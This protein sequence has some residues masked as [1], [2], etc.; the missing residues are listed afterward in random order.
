MNDH[1]HLQAFE[2]DISGTLDAGDGKGVAP[3]PVSDR[4][5]NT[6]YPHW[7]SD[8]P[9]ILSAG[10]ICGLLTAMFAISAAALL[11][12]TVLSS[13]ITL[14]IGICLM[15]TIALNVVI[16]LFSSCPGMVS[17]TQEV[18]VVTLAVIAVTIHGTMFTTHSE[19]EILATIIVMI[20]LATAMTGVALFAMGKFQLGRLIRFIPYPVLAGFLAGMG[21]LIITGAMAV[22]LGFPLSLRTMPALLDSANL[23]KWV[24]AVA[25]ALA[26]DLIARR[27]GSPLVLPL[28]IAVVLLL[29]HATTW[30]LDLPT[31]EL[32][33]QGWLFA[34]PQNGSIDLPFQNNPF[35]LADWAVIWSQIPKMV[36]LLAVS[37]VALLFASSG[38][39]LSIRREIDLDRE[40][41][42]AGIANIL[43]GAGG[44]AAGFQ[45]LGLTILAHHTGAPYRATGVLV[46]V[47]C[48]AVLFFGATLLSV[49]PVPLFGGLLLW[50]GG[51]LLWQWL[52]GIYT[53]VSRR[54]HLVVILIVGLI[55][56]IGLLEGVVFGVFAAAALFALEYARVD[57]IK[58]A[59]TGEACS[60][61]VQHEAEDHISLCRAGPE[62]R[63]LRL[64]GFIFF[65][66]VQQLHNRIGACFD[67]SDT[68]TIRFLVLDC[69][70]VTGFDSSAVQSL[71]KICDTMRKNDVRLIISALNSDLIERLQRQ[72]FHGA[73]TGSHLYFD[74]IDQALAWCECRLSEERAH[75]PCKRPTRPAQALK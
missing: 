21:W 44:G 32:Q 41:R 58:N 55:I 50:I 71:T 42:V 38:I 16:A 48:A 30:L 6:P 12:S 74:E 60:S 63:I 7:F 64:Q 36:A 20:G 45:G 26:V 4:E 29:F 17:V 3:Q 23:F 65:G 39:G 73:Q 31:A 14:A 66:N 19:A 46:A 15:G 69:R 75:L 13:H 40:L 67:K 9:A 62:T 57:I 1:T 61:R 22:V 53:R 11:F 10:L 56:T 70:D 8:L 35:A 68:S 18:T 28:S 43:A 59:V 5:T 52:I 72:L 33:R 54:E 51:G 37:A 49:I 34:P 2:P 24:P 27:S 47:V 25:F